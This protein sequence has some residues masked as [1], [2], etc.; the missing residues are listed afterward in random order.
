MTLRA[1]Q[2][3]RAVIVEV[4]DQGAG[5]PAGEEQRIFEKFYRV[6]GQARAGTGIGLAICRSIITMHHGTLVAENRPGGGAVFR[7]SLPL[8]T[9]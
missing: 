6:E 7:F 8:G 9:E 4:A 2:E 3:G 1:Y 5:F